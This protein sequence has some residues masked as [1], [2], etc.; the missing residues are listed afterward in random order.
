MKRHTTVDAYIDAA[1]RWQDE[2]R[3]LRAILI[4]T[5]L[6][7]TI[8]WGMPCYTVRGKNVVGLAGFKA[9]VGLWFFE[10]ARLKDARQLLINAQPGQT[11]ALRQW[12][13]SSGAEIKPRLVASYVKEAIG[14]VGADARPKRRKG[15][16]KR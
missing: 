3:R 1:D 11:K 12:R 9:Y 14:L 8:K 2:L 16:A 10:G 13:F 6:E 7:E 4:S 15:M 5:G